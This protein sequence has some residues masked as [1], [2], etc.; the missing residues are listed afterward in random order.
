MLPGRPAL[1]FPDGLLMHSWGAATT[2]RRRR[3]LWSDGRSCSASGLLQQHLLAS[4]PGRMWLWSISDLFAPLDLDKLPLENKR[5][6]RFQTCSFVIDC[7]AAR[8]WEH[9]DGFLFPLQTRMEGVREAFMFSFSWGM[10]VH[11]ST[12]ASPSAEDLDQSLDESQIRCDGLA[13]YIKTL[14]FSFK[15]NGSYSQLMQV[16]FTSGGCFCS[17][18]ALYFCMFSS[19]QTHIFMLCSI[20]VVD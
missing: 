12:E 11:E 6:H 7:A 16:W 1:H 10:S 20:A 4:L 13:F 18:C 9:Q 15:G 5:R 14:T 19:H 3:Q 17:K 2:R 8:V